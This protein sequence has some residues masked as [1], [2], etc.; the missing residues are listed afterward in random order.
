M[1]FGTRKIKPGAKTGPARDFPI[2]ECFACGALRGGDS[3]GETQVKVARSEDIIRPKRD[4]FPFV[5][6][7]RAVQNDVGIMAARQTKRPVLLE[8][9]PQRGNDRFDQARFG[10]FIP[11]RGD[12]DG[13]RPG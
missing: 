4:P 11:E 12:L 6:Q 5:A 3:R 9:F 13:F 8:L 7:Q 2:D 1:T 10:G